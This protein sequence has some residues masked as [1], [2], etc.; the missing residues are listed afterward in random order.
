[1]GLRPPARGRRALVS[2]TPRLMFC[3]AVCEL[4][5][6]LEREEEAIAA[7]LGVTA[8]D[9]RIRLGGVLPRIMAQRDDVASTLAFAEALR[10]RGHGAIVFDTNDALAL[11]RMR[12]MRRFGV[13]GETLFANDGAP[14]GRP[15]TDLVAIVHA[16]L[17]VSVVRTTREV[18]LRATGRGTAR[19]EEKRTVT[20]R[21][22]EKIAVLFWRAGEPWLLRQSEARYVALGSDL[23]STNS[24]NFEL[25]VEWLRARSPAAVY[26]RRFV[27]S[28]LTP[29]RAVPVRDAEQARSLSSDRSVELTLHALGAWLSRERAGPYR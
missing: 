15:L 21:S 22:L 18:V 9:V 29:Q 19:S 4:G 17:D 10:K 20:E 24:Q 3:L 12:L 1:M 7:V 27:A 11:E 23:R 14:P 5:A 6:P 8:Y 16:S 28:P 25:A 13:E 26:D 2:M